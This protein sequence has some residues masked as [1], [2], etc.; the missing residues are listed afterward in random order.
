MAMANTKEKAITKEMATAKAW[1]AEMDVKLLLTYIDVA[2]TA[3]TNGKAVNWAHIATVM[4]KTAEGV[5]YV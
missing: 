2:V 4:G 3:N 5:R 1:T